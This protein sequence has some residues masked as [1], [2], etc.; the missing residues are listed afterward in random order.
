MAKKEEKSKIVLERTYN[1]PL[2][3]E[4][5]KAPNWKRTPRAVRALKAFLIKHMKSD[6]V[7]IGKYANNELWKHGIKNPPHHIKVHVT[8][9]SE[10]VVVAELMN[11]KRR[12]F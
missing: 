11:Q 9:D 1:V 5:Q 3:K 10:G 6:N 2:R 7:R 12:K 8:K 4:T